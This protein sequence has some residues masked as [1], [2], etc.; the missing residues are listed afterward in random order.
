MMKLQV[1]YGILPEI[2]E[3]LP[4]RFFSKVMKM[5]HFNDFDHLGKKVYS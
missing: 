5:A 4:S 2:Q 1:L 3:F